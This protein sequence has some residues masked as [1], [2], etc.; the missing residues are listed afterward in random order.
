MNASA[1]QNFS[2]YAKLFPIL[3]S[4]RFSLEET[5]RILDAIAAGGFGKIFIGQRDDRLV[6]F[7]NAWID[8][9]YEVMVSQDLPTRTAVLQHKFYGNAEAALRA[10]L[11]A[12]RDPYQ[13]L[14]NGK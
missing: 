13:N 1:R 4:H 3:E 12:V 14:T 2:L 5:F 8:D 10:A 11:L 9:A 7:S 6:F